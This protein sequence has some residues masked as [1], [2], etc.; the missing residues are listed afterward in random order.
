MPDQHT[1]I[2]LIILIGVF[3]LLIISL[4]K[5]GVDAT[6]KIAGIF[7]MFLGGIV[8]YYFTKT[9]ISNEYQQQN[10]SN[11]AIIEKNKATIKQ[12]DNEL[13]K[14]KS[15]TS[16]LSIEYQLLKNK[17]VSQRANATNP[18]G[19]GN[20][21]SIQQRNIEK[22]LKDLETIDGN[23][24]TIAIAPIISDKSSQ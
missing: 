2:A 16:N 24:K 7:T 12:K 3:A 8:S 23:K 13:D 22:L 18:F 21:I 19:T 10:I 15:I 4:I 11:Q 17:L 6:S 14:Y 5:Y 9:S 1:T 20:E